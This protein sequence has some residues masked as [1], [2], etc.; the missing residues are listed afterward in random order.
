MAKL[1]AVLGVV[2]L[3]VL[4]AGCGSESNT[5]ASSSTTTI[6]ARSVVGVRR[7]VRA[8]VRARLHVSRDRRAS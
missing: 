1:M 5:T 7:E 8:C 2:A 3:L 4:G 6:Q